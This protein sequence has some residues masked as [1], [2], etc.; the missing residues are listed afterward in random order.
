MI[1]DGAIAMSSLTSSPE[2]THQ[3]WISKET[4]KEILPGLE[5][6]DYQ[7]LGV[8]WLA[9]LHSMTCELMSDKNKKGNKSRT[10]N[11]NGILADGTFTVYFYGSI[12]SLSF[13]TP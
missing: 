10:T 9:M 5:L 3:N 11:V 4:M 12:H 8:N 1:V 13:T 6:A 7:L 2:S